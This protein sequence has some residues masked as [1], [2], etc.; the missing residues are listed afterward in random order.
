L[1]NTKLLLSFNNKKIK[2]QGGHL[3]FT[4][5]KMANIDLSLK[6]ILYDTKEGYN[7]KEAKWIRE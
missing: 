4:S 3:S 7:K 5:K 1:T 6:L 2:V